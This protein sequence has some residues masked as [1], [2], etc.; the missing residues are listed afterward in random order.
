MTTVAEST[1]FVPSF[2]AIDHVNALPTQRALKDEI[3]LYQ[4]SLEFAE[5]NAGPI[6]SEFLY[7]LP[8]SFKENIVIDSRVHYLQSGYY[9]AIPGYHLDWIPRKNNGTS[10]DLSV[11]PDYQHIVMVVAQ[12]SLT[13]FVAEN[14]DLPLLFVAPEERA[15]SYANDTIKLSGVNTRHVE[16]GD[17]VLFTSRDWHRPVPAEVDE[18]RYFIRASKVSHAKPKNQIRIQAQ[19]YIPIEEASW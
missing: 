9:P 5:S 18:W 17:M 16:N 3:M 15:F 4:A 11:I 7:K 13:E 1:T 19:V 2:Q 6:M 14:I 10:P 12:T 8:S